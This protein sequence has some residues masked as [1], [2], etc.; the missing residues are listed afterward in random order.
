V[1]CTANS[2]TSNVFYT[3]ANGGN[4]GASNSNTGSSSI[5]SLFSNGS[6]GSE[7]FHLAGAAGSTLADDFVAPGGSD[8]SLATD[9]D[10]ETRPQDVNRDA[11]A[12]ER[13]SP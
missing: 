3:V 12:D 13:D 10:G 9:V 4:C 1:L 11:G 2:W 8:S 6:P 5:G 7:N